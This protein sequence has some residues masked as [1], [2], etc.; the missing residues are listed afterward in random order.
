VA[1]PG[2][3]SDGH[4]Y[5]EDAVQRGAAAVVTEKDRSGDFRVPSVQVPCTRIALARISRAVYQYPDR[6]LT[7]I[8]VT[9]TNGKTSV[10]RFV[11][12]FLQAA[13]R[14]A[15]SLGTVGYSFAGR[16]LPARRTTPGAPDLHRILADMRRA[17]CGYCAMEVSSHALDQNRVFGLEMDV[18]V[19]TNLSQDHLDYHESMESYFEAKRKLFDMQGVRTR[20][21]GE[22]EWSNRLADHY[23]PD[24]I[25]CGL[26]MDCQVRAERVESTL[27]GTVAHVITPWGEGVLRIPLPGVYN[28]RN[29]LQ[30]LA[31][32]A[33]VGVPVETL[34]SASE[35]LDAAPGRMQLIPGRTGRVYVDYAHTP[36]ALANVLGLLKQLAKGR[37]I[38]VFGCG[39]DRDRLK[40]PLMVKAAAACADQMIFTLDNPRNEDPEQIFQDMKEGLEAGQDVTVEPDRTRA[41]RSAVESLQRGDVLLIAGKGHESIQE[42]GA[43]QIPYD[44]RDVAARCIAER[45][46][47]SVGD[48]AH[49]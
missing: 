18:A 45:D 13:G 44:D 16:E 40:R 24:V 31:A 22:D 48:G 10:T 43:V 33:S 38:V 4:R 21:V 25:R 32:A 12:H 29:A 37:V 1:I 34:L 28:L 42:I 49:A 5:L 19:F 8:G 17:G 11:Q 39:G 26:G 27:A 20:I 47:Q 7:L 9:G 30:A 2:H 41:I 3:D 23:G 35:R 14:S 36:D 15:G 6:E 46:R